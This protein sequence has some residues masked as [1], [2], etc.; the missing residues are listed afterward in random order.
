MTRPTAAI[1]ALGLTAVA[2][3][4]LAQNQNTLTARLS[5]VPISTSLQKDVSGK[6]S[7]MASLSGRRL[8]VTGA[9]EGL[10]AA[11][12]L[13][14]LRRG[15]ATGAAGPAIAELTV[16]H[17]ASG[18]LLGEVELNRDQRAALLAG[19]LYIQLYAEH[20][21]PP[22]NAVLRGWLLSPAPERER[23]AAR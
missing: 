7:A 8:T 6:G 4:A 11:A 23:R 16:T 19:Q 21:V 2:G 20:G 14:E 10:P 5:W 3:L 17:A 13:A 18:T 9:F 1:F 22:D 15:V 12:T